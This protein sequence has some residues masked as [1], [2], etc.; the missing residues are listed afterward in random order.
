MHWLLR[1]LY[2]YSVLLINENI[3]R[4]EGG[5]SQNNW[6]LN[7]SHINNDYD[8]DDDDAPSLSSLTS[9]HDKERRL[10][11]HSLIDSQLLGPLW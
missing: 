11:I 3:T 2:S 7:R 4:T 6:L 9:K 5:L 8:D 1:L 10:P